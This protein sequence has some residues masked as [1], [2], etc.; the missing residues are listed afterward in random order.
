MTW[1]LPSKQA[2]CPVHKILVLEGPNLVAV[3]ERLCA[4]PT[5]RGE[6]KYRTL[7][8]SNRLTLYRVRTTIVLNV[9][10]AQRHS[11][12]AINVHPFRMKPFGCG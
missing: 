7:K 2:T 4:K 9:G 11:P 10:F 1:N 5:V 12:T 3:G 6:S 8:G